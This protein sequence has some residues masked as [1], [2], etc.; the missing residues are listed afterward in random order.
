MSEKIRVIIADVQKMDLSAEEVLPQIAPRYVEKYKRFKIETEANQELVTGYLLM[1]YLGVVE[2]EQLKLNEQG[3]PFLSD[4]SPFFN[5]SHSGNY[6]VLAIAD[7][8]IGVDIERIR[9]YHEATAKRV[10]TE[11]QFLMLQG[12]ENEEQNEAFSKMW[13]EC[14]AILK[15]QGTGFTIDWNQIKESGSGCSVE[16]MQ[17]KDYFISCAAKK[18]ISVMLEEEKG[19]EA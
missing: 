13:T 18:A 7:C 9:K 2:D 10:F 19:K 5:V 11:K 6:V 1:K 4:G 17:Y 14:E 8:E 3:K 12:L 15:L 16:C